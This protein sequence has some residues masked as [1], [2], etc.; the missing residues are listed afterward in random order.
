MAVLLRDASLW[1]G[2]G[3]DVK[4]HVDVLIE[5][6][7]V[8][9][10]QPSGQ[11]ISADGER[12]IDLDGAFLMPGLIDWHVHLV[13][14]GSADPVAAVDAD[15]QHLTTIRATANSRAELGG[16]VTTVCD[17]GGNWDIPI[18]LSRAVARGYFEGP[19]IVAAGQTVVITGGHDGFWGIPSDGPDAVVRTVRRQVS[20]GAGVIKVSATGGAYGRPEGEEIG[21]CELTYEELSA[22]A[23]ESHRFGLK[24]AAHALG[25]EGIR[26]AV[27]AGIDVIHHGNFLDEETVGEMKQRHTFFCPTLLTYRTLAEGTEGGIPAYA[28]QKAQ[29]TVRAHRESFRMALEAGIQIVAG[30]DAGSPRIPHPV[31]IPELQLM[32]EYGMPTEQV[33]RSATSIAAQALGQAD[34][35]GTVEQGRCADLLV[36]ERNPLEDLTNLRQVRYIVR[37][38]RVIEPGALI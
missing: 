33:L 4:H 26:N 35:F 1:D 23:V 18:S 20:L 32:R 21:Q 12:L 28:V 34:R 13:W 7:I 36:L 24:A 37:S 9:S 22:A 2:T 17:L 27:R 5:R 30:T 19:R 6:G 29:R 31:I 25:T 16:G 8:R 14:S 15:G 11:A 38:G 10:I 3:A